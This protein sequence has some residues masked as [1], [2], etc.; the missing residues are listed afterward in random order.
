MVSKA[1]ISKTP[2]KKNE[3]AQSATPRVKAEKLKFNLL[4]TSLES[5]NRERQKQTAPRIKADS[6][7]R[8]MEEATMRFAL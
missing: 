2:A 5:T 8:S 3:N 6:N 7:N 4:E 1:R